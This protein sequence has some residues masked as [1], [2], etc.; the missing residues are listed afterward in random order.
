LHLAKSERGAP[1]EVGV[2]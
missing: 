2:R 1:G